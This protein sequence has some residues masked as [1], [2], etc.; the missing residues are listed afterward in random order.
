M[1]VECRPRRD[2]KR[3]RENDTVCGLGSNLG[4]LETNLRIG[5]SG[6]TGPVYLDEQKKQFPEPNG[7]VL[8]YH[9]GLSLVVDT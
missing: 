8:S 2:H 5:R 4:R 9:N 3:C 7:A 1:R 6:A